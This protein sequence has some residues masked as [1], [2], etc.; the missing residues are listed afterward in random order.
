MLSSQLTHSAAPGF[1][2]VPSLAFKT[3]L[4]KNLNSILRD[5]GAH[6]RKFD[7]LRFSL[8]NNATKVASDVSLYNRLSSEVEGKVLS[9][10]KQDKDRLCKKF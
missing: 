9:K 10:Y 6:L 4:A 2:P 8:K 7:E 3:A 1:R 5:S